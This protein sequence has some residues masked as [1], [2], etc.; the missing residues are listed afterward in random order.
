MWA[1]R[2]RG[3]E[4]DSRGFGLSSPKKWPF[5]ESGRTVGGAGLGRKVSLALDVLRCCLEMSTRQLGDVSLGRTGAVFGSHGQGGG[6]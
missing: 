5:S 4:G 2:E 3:V 1:V 6:W